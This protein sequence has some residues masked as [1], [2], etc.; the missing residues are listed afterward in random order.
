MLAFINKAG[1]IKRSFAFDFIR[2]DNSSRPQWC[3]YGSSR[4]AILEKMIVMAERVC[5]QHLSWRQNK[6]NAHRQISGVVC[7]PTF[8]RS[9]KPSL[10]S[11]QPAFRRIICN[12][13]LA[14]VY[15]HLRISNQVRQWQRPSHHQH[16]H[17]GKICRPRVSASNREIPPN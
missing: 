17:D 12:Q 14:F 1:T 2:L 4:L 13:N 5:C 11:T 8:I 16:Q 15:S 7:L 9:S 10:R 3:H 6:I